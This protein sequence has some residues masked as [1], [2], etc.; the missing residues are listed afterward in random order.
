[1]WEGQEGERIDTHGRGRLVSDMEGETVLMEGERRV[2]GVGR[3]G[4]GLTLRGYG[5]E[6][7]GV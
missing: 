4:W 3:M 7:V 5:C 2:L 6:R 1:V